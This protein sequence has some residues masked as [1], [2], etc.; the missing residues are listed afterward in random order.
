MFLCSYPFLSRF[1]SP[2]PRKLPNYPLSFFFWC[3]YIYIY[4][5]GPGPSF[6]LLH[7]HPYLDSGG[8]TLL[9]STKILLGGGLVVTLGLWAAVL[10]ATR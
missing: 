3:G 4:I 1:L 10:H 5:I 6:D 9:A 8:V 7:S 2:S